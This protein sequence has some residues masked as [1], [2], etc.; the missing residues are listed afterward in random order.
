MPKYIGFNPAANSSVTRI[1][2]SDSTLLYLPFDSSVTADSSPENVTVTSYGQA[3]LD[4][5][6]KA[7]G[8]SSLALSETSGADYLT[9]PTMA[10]TG[11]FTIEGF[12]RTTIAQTGSSPSTRQSLFTYSIYNDVPDSYA[13]L[14]FWLQGDGT[15]R[16]YAS[17]GGNTWDVAS[18]QLWGNLTVNT[19]HHFALSRE[20]TTLRTYF[21][22]TR[23][24]E[25]SNPGSFHTSA[26]TSALGSRDTN[27]AYGFN[28][29]I[30]DFRIVGFALYTGASLTVPTFPVTFPTVGNVDKKELSSVWDNK[31]Y[32]KLRKL[33]KL[34]NAKLQSSP[35]HRWNPANVGGTP[36]TTATGGSIATPGNGYRYHVFTSP[37]TFQ[38]SA[39]DGGSPSLAVEYLVVAGGGGGGADRAGGGGAGGLRTNEDGNPKAGAAMNIAT[40][41]FPVVVGTGGA[42]GVWPSPTTSDQGGTSS[43]N[44]ISAAGGGTANIGAGGAG[45]SGGGGGTSSTGAGA[46]NTPPTSPPQGNPGGTGHYPQ[47]AGGGGGAGAAGSA[48]NPNAGAGGAGHAMPSFTGPILSPVIPGSM[49]TAIGPTGL[50]AGG[51]GGGGSGAGPNIAGAG[52]PGGGGAGGN[53][54]VS[55]SSYNPTSGEYGPAGAPGVDGTGGGGG[56]AGNFPGTNPNMRP[57]GDGGNGVVIIKYAY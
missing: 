24:L 38:L 23:T 22:G 45:G 27:G 52:G 48:G 18:N 50:Y 41:S 31:Q 37:G 28:G 20:G 30:D 1:T 25:L 4:T 10:L 54:N 6:N 26:A 33:G 49:S 14:A 13:G 44:G 40:G 43:F 57:G 35:D 9:F 53:A 56:G 34:D 17:S 16:L 19:F 55:P 39:I 32:F 36:G 51:G 29:Q 7:V 21:D 3:S 15:L 2:T 12:F 42:G 8:A 46:G 47:G 11:D 5:S